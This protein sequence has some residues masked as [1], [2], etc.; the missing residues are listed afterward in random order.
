[1]CEKE[2][3]VCSG[4][5]TFFGKSVTA[6]DG[7]LW[8][9][10]ESKGLFLPLLHPQTKVPMFEKVCWE[11]I[12]DVMVVGRKAPNVSDVSETSIEAGET[13]SALPVSEQPGWL[14]DADSRLYFAQHNPC[15][16]VFLWK[17]KPTPCWPDDASLVRQAHEIQQLAGGFSGARF[18]HEQVTADRWGVT[19]ASLE[20][21]FTTVEEKH[22]SGAL[23]N[24]GR[25]YYESKFQSSSIG[26]NMYQVNEQV[27]VPATADPLQPFP[28]VSWALHGSPAGA[29][30]THFVTHAW[31][32]GVFEF[33]RFLMQAWPLNDVNAAA[34]I[35]FLSNPQNLDIA[36]MLASVETSPFHVALQN[37]PTHGSMIMVATENTPIHTR[38]WC[39]F[40]AHMALCRHIPITLVGCPANLATDSSAV[41]AQFEAESFDAYLANDAYLEVAGAA[42]GLRND[43]LD[44]CCP[45]LKRRRE[46]ALAAEE[47]KWRKS[48]PER[49]HAQLVTVWVTTVTMSVGMVIFVVWCATWSYGYFWTSFMTNGGIAFIFFPILLLCAAGFRTCT[50]NRQ[51]EL[52]QSAGSGGFIDVQDAQCSSPEDEARIRASIA[53]Q[54][55]RIN[56]LLGSL[57]LRQ[58]L[59]STTRTATEP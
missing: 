36:A 19:L 52:L 26:P 7:S 57:I 47:E 34:Y 28:G 4:G 49:L 45:A 9:W 27:I 23:Q 12:C 53:G 39:V 13:I 15:T 10:N 48:T 3:S 38:L 59:G 29:R 42:G 14:M 11:C 55:R 54:E 1:M 43:A 33:R 8:L 46:A 32:E 56:S 30:V 24:A 31:A 20:S 50:V 37:M 21:F 17:E 41:V 51:I 40:E 6:E 58:G 44:S 2:G 25:P 35:C 5:D 18:L 22:R 16:G